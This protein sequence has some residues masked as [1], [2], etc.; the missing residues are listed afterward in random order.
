[1]ETLVATDGNYSTEV[2]ASFLDNHTEGMKHDLFAHPTESGRVDDESIRDAAVL[3]TKMRDVIQW[4]RD[5]IPAELTPP[6]GIV[7]E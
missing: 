4:I 3:N 5:L 1:M 7:W 6:L 2:A